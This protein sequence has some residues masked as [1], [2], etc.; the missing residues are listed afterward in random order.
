MDPVRSEA[1]AAV[2]AVWRDLSGV[3][4]AAEHFIPTQ[5]QSVP[6]PPPLLARFHYVELRVAASCCSAGQMWGAEPRRW[7]DGELTDGGF[8]RTPS[9][10]VQL[11]LEA[12]AVL[13]RHS[14]A[15]AVM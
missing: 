12:S 3:S 4:N 1:A 11:R 14:D 13:E 7:T 8:S 2:F 6:P 15:L 10:W 9:A 5:E